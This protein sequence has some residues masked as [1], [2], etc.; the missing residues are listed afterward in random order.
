MTRHRGGD[1]VEMGW[2]LEVRRLAP[3]HL[4]ARGRLPGSRRDSYLAVPWPAMLVLA[5]LAGGAWLLAAPVVGLA[6][7]A[8]GLL[9]RAGGAGAGGL[10]SAAAHRHVPGEAHLT[11]GQGG[12]EARP[13]GSLDELERHVAGR[14]RGTE[15]RS[16]R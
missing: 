10:A 14:R 6:T 13:T 8:W 5:P 9:R 1:L 2:Y 4:A 12:G 16:G 11:G 15:R 7:A 3:L